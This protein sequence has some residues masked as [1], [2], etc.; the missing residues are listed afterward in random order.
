MGSFTIHIFRIVLRFWDHGLF[1]YLDSRYAPV[2]D[3]CSVDAPPEKKLRPWALKDFTAAFLVLGFGVCIS[4]LAFIFE[5]IVNF[6]AIMW[7]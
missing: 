3:T 1:Y 6:I 2:T 4:I 5:H 7:K